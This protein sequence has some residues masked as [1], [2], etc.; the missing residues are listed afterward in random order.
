[1]RLFPS[2]VSLFLCVVIA[3]TSEAGKRHRPAGAGDSAAT[4]TPAPPP[5]II[6]PVELPSANPTRFM[7]AHVAALSDITPAGRQASI[8]Y[9]TDVSLLRTA[10]QAGA[11]AA[12]PEKKATY[13]A[14]L[15]ACDVLAAA[16]EEHD[17]AAADYASAQAGPDTH[18]VKDVR[19][20]TRAGPAR[21]WKGN[22]REQRQG[23]RREQSAGFQ[24]SLHELCGPECLD[25]P[26]R[27][28]A[29]AD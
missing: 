21:V 28:T 7:Q 13:S 18:D 29:P 15:R 27:S 4:P 6:N 11:A 22:A 25:E 23:K 3:T 20:S 5:A 17:K 24:P 2:F 16:I 9:R 19:I 1:M 12:T 26:G 8:A 10:F 14:A